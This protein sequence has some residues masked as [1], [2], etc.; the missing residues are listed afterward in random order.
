MKKYHLVIITLLFFSTACTNRKANF[1]QEASFISTDTL[2]ENPLLEKVLTASINTNDSSMSTLYA[3]KIAWE[4]AIN[5]TDINYPP[6][7]ILY[8]VTWKQKADSLWFGANIPK[9]IKSV[10]RISYNNNSPAGYELYEGRPLQK[11][12]S[13]IDTIRI[14][15]I[16]KQKMAI[17]P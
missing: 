4:Y 13:I 9:E 6:G 15:T 16:I 5:H 12:S 2:P 17:S 8:Q 14:A 3:N 7:S 1:N 10:E 11:S